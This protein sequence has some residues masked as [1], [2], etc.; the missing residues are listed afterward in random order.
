M[1]ICSYILALNEMRTGRADSER[2]S[3]EMPCVS[4][5]S[6]ESPVPVSKDGS[7]YVTHDI[8]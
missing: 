3:G 5:I 8:N 6:A 2:R 1:S 7:I 4:E